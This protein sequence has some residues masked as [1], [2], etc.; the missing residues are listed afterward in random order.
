MWLIESMLG[1]GS[2]RRKSSERER[3][4]NPQALD[5]VALAHLASILATHPA[6]RNMTPRAIQRSRR[7]LE[8]LLAHLPP[9][10]IL[11]PLRPPLPLHLNRLQQSLMLNSSIRAGSLNQRFTSIARRTIFACSVVKRV[12]KLQIVGSTLKMPKGRPLPWNP[13]PSQKNRQ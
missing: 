10:T 13:L 4:T 5:Q 8:N 12:T 11:L 7:I 2:G 9:L 1:I 3:R 6:V